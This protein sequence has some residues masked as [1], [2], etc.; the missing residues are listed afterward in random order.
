MHL[1]QNSSQYFGEFAAL[2]TIYESRSLFEPK[3]YTQDDSTKSSMALGTNL[4]VA[5]KSSE[6]AILIWPDRRN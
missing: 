4:G 3:V 1:L 2:Q 6:E 5:W